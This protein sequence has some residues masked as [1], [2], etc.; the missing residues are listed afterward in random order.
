[1]EDVQKVPFFK[2][3]VHKKE[4]KLSKLHISPEKNKS[5]EHFLQGL[6]KYLY[7]CCIAI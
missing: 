7:N 6:K 4:I 5:D 1:L 3:F 2:Q